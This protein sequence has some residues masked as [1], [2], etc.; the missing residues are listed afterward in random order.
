MGDLRMPD[1]NT[2]ILAGRLTRD[3][4]SKIIGDNISLCTL[5]LAVSKKF[6]TK[7][8]D[9]KEETIFVDV[10]CWRGT[11]D[12]VALHLKKGYPVMVSGRLKG[13]EWQDKTTGDTRRKLFID[14][15]R[16][17][18]LEWDNNNASPGGGNQ[19][20]KQKQRLIEEPTES[21]DM[22]F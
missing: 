16:V 2:V 15:D 21:D 14:A 12:W 6:K 20:A 18:H 17:Q 1:I 10:T 13:D 4:E 7:A 5:G 11:A 3:P 8:G 19:P 9:L 22:P